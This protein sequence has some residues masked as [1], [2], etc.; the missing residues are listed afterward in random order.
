MPQQKQ[1]QHQ[2]DSS[3]YHNASYSKPLLTQNVVS[4]LVL[5]NISN[6]TNKR[7][8]YSKGLSDNAAL[9]ES[10]LARPA[11]ALTNVGQNSDQGD[12]KSCHVEHLLATEGNVLEKYADV[13]SSDKGKL[14]EDKGSHT[15]GGLIQ[16]D[17]K[18][19]I[20]KG[21]NF[22]VKFMFLLF[23]MSLVEEG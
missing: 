18:V 3:C 16:G 21:I 19:C 12:Q 17:N 13:D 22:V 10:N 15:V 4:I 6:H 1:Y 9:C 20:L 8:N 23:I 5:V 11:H 14:E 2:C 7:Q